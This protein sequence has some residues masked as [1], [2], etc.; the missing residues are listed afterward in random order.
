MGLNG[1]GRRGFLVGAAKA[2]VAVPMLSSLGEPVWADK[3][4]GAV[5][6]K[7]T[8]PPLLLRSRLSG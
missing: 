6:K 8:A 1:E 2:L 7:V 3:P 5:P 4:G